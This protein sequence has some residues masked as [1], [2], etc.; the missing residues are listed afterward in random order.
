MRSYYRNVQGV[1]QDPF[2]SYNPIFK[3]ERIFCLLH[4]R[5]LLGDRAIASGGRGSAAALEGRWASTRRTASTS[6][7]T[8]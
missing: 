1:F 5:F 8:S 6:T 4:D 7:R 2:S 3:A